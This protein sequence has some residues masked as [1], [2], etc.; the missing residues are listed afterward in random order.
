MRSARSRDGRR[1]AQAPPAP[2]APLRCATVLGLASAPFPIGLCQRISRAMA[3]GDK[4]KETTMT[5]K[6]YP[7]FD[8]YAVSGEGRS[9]DWI[10]VGAAWHNKDGEGLSITL[11]DGVSITAKRLVLNPYEPSKKN[12]E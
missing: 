5:D 11:K 9:A 8:V 2:L 7:A 12:A 10:K 3:R 6:N 1:S 4:P